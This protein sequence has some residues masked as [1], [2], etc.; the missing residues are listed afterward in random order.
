MLFS[1]YYLRR[2]VMSISPITGDVDYDAGC[3]CLVIFLL[4]FS[5]IESILAEDTWYINILLL[6]TP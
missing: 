6:F 4:S 3:V 2:H 5:L 1:M